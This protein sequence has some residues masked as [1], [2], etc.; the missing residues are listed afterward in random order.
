MYG[1]ADLD[2]IFETR[3]EELYGVESVGEKYGTNKI[4][5]LKNINTAF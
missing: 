5:D 3:K 4:L 1:N 2:G